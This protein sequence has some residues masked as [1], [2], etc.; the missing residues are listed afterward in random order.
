M[1][2]SLSQF[3]M[4][5]AATASAS[6]PYFANVWSLL[7]F[8][9]TDGSA[10][11]TDVIPAR[12]WTQVGGA[13]LDTSIKLFGSASLHCP[14]TGIK[15]NA[16]ATVGIGTGDCCI[17]WAQYWDD[18]TGYQTAFSY[19][20]VSSGALLAQ[21]TSGTGLY[22]IYVSGTKIFSETS[23]TPSLN[24]WYRYA[25]V[26]SSGVITLYRNGV[27]AGSA[28]SSASIAPSGVPWAWGVDPSQGYG[29]NANLDECRITVGVPRYTGD[30][31]PATGPFPDH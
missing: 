28:S 29:I 26:R 18:L 6:D 3:Q 31:T 2:P 1:R 23:S 7:H 22:D 11:F 9:G 19:G 21:T 20:Y 27:A 5:M 10:T 4:M 24:T 16:T 25:L 17:E 13:L 15:T 8:D 12:G 14:T 30:Y